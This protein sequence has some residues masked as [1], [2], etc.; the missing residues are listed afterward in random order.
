MSNKETLLNVLYSF[1]EFIHR[2][3]QYL[4][5]EYHLEEPVIVAKM[6][7]I[8]PQIGMIQKED[9]ILMTFR[10][11]GVGCLFKFGEIMVDFDYEREGFTYK[12]FDIHKFYL[13]VKSYLPSSEFLS[14]PV[15]LDT[16]I[17]LLVDRKIENIDHVQYRLLQ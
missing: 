5:E 4:Q 12:Y 8:I 16:L 7:G 13:F 17:E 9:V 11:H 2:G 15:Y 14:E 1:E 6:R 10:F 3:N